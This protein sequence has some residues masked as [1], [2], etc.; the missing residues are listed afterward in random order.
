MW[1]GLNLMDYNRLRLFLSLGQAFLPI[2]VKNKGDCVQIFLKDGSSDILD[3]RCEVFFST[4]LS[5]FGT[6]ISIN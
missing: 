3:V 5:Y 1:K 6:N 4:L 2:N